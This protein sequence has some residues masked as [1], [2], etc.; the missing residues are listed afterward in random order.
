MTVESHLAPMNELVSQFPLMQTHQELSYLDSAATTQKPRCVIDAVAT[1]YQQHNA[2][3]HRGIYTLSEESTAKFETCRSQAQQFLNAANSNEIIFTAGVTA[4]MNLLATSFSTLLNPGDEVLISSMEHHAVIVPWQRACAVSGATLKVI[5]LTDTLELDLDAYQQLLN[6]KTR[7]VSLIHVSNVLGT[8]NP[9]KSMIDM[10]HAVDAAVIIDGAQAAAHEPIDVQALDC[11]FYTFSAHKAY[12]PTGVG[13]LYGKA[14]WLDRLPPYQLGGDM[15]RTVSFQESTYNDLP[16]KFEAGTPN[17]AGVI[18]LGAALSFITQLSQ[19]AIS[20]HEK[21]LLAYANDQLSQL[22]GL[23]ILG[24]SMPKIGVISMTLDCAHPHD[25]AT[26]LS[27]ANVAV[28]AGHHCAMP[29]MGL[30]NVS[31]TVRASFGVY[32]TQK[33]I[34]QLVGGL[35][36]VINLFGDV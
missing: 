31:S 22:P 30:M 3:V 34:D 28:R 17:M 29:L 10:A 23:T 32:T 2:N 14:A 4:A 16:Y 26:I 20:K 1:Y 13:V 21:A 33:D 6:E 9:I 7:V 5:P 24:A 25:I 19:P 35:H 8:I 15:I 36:Q 18:G 11:D 27:D 12:G